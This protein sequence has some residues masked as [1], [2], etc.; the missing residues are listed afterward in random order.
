M[1]FI[2]SYSKDNLSKDITQYVYNKSGILTTEGAD[3]IFAKALEID[4]GNDKSQ[5]KFFIRTFNNTPFDPLGPDGKRDV[6][7]RTEMKPVSQNT[8]DYYIMY[9]RSKNSLYM[10]RTQRSFING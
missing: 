3:K 1:K 8:F 7:S 10:T 4:L 6:W 9:L 2:E 5:K